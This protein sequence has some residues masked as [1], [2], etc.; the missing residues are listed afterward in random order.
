MSTKR[1][2][3]KKENQS[4][5]S[6]NKPL[7]STSHNDDLLK[8]N[9]SSIADSVTQ[10]TH[11]QIGQT[12]KISNYK[13]ISKLIDIL[14]YFNIRHI[15]SWSQDGSEIEIKDERKFIDEVLPMFFKHSNMSN[16]IR[17]LN[18]YNFKKVKQYHI[19]GV[20][21]YKNPFFKR[22]ANTM[23]AEIN[24][25]SPHNLQENS[26]R[27]EPAKTVNEVSPSLVKEL[28][29]NPQLKSEAHPNKIAID[30]F[31]KLQG[32][33]QKISNLEKANDSLV[34]HSAE[35]SQ[36]LVG[37]A[38]Y[39]RRLESLIFY[40]IHQVLPANMVNGDSDLKNL[41]CLNNLKPVGISQSNHEQ[42][43]GHSY[44]PAASNNNC[45]KNDI[46]NDDISSLH[47]HIIKDIQQ[48]NGQLLGTKRKLKA[49]QSKTQNNFQEMS[50]SR[51]GKSEDFFKDLV[52]KYQEYDMSFIK[53]KTAIGIEI[54]DPNNSVKKRNVQ[55]NAISVAKF[56]AEA[57]QKG[58]ILQQNLDLNR[59]STSIV[60]TQASSR[61][62][63]SDNDQNFMTKKVSSFSSTKTT[64]NMYDKNILYLNSNLSSINPFNLSEANLSNFDLFSKP[65]AIRAPTTH[66]ETLH[67][68]ASFE[69]K[70][71]KSFINDLYFVEAEDKENAIKSKDPES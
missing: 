66:K 47:N 29:D 38:D 31:K 17:Q 43:L 44:E 25:K 24:R 71:N 61:L 69:N 19:P 20:S 3:T 10:K 46:E 15:V 16:F 40:I 6:I 8:L 51:D 7:F 60:A 32:L 2:I 49:I 52:A 1:S 48:Y 14:S 18:M 13:F 37:K 30:L 50:D 35:F 9:C 45:L 22:E 63:Q 5:I 62:N 64:E 55:S 57:D 54:E 12:E 67:R 27:N 39:I 23:I 21:A 70:K 11:T 65:Q 28:T 42:I 58:N 33:E 26:K 59:I 53:P 68:I 34:D 56:K 36:K 41:K 4:E